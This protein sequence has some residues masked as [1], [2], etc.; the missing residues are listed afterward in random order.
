MLRDI[1][2]VFF[3]VA[4][5]LL[6]WLNFRPQKIVLT[7][8]DDADVANPHPEQNASDD[9]LV[10]VPHLVAEGAESL[11]RAEDGDARPEGDLALEADQRITLKEM[12]R[13]ARTGS[14]PDDRR[15]AFVALIGAARSPAACSR[16]KGDDHDADQ[17]G[18]AHRPDH[19][20]RRGDQVSQ[21]S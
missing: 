2:T 20:D 8:D 3:I 11:T 7:K 12:A 17:E 18:A 19:G 4:G 16:A 13:N 1:L 10:P 5:C 14:T 21:P 6:L 9:D 15:R